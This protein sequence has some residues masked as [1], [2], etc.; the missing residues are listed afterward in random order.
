MTLSLRNRQV[1][2]ISVVT[3]TGRLIEGPEANALRQRLTDLLAFDPRV[4]LD[5]GGIDFIDSSGLGLL[6]R[7]LTRAQAQR[8][9]IKLCAVPRELA[10][11]LKVTR[12]GALFDTH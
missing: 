4:V 3:C 5:L 6:V 1:G 9:D 2:D 7:M 8:G 12:L 11:I 10:K